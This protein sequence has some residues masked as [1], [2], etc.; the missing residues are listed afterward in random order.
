M[1]QSRTAFS[2]NVALRLVVSG[3]VLTLAQVGPDFVILKETTTVNSDKAIVEVMIENRI[4]S[5]TAVALPN[6]ICPSEKRIAI[7]NT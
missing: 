7:S 4:A 3:Q 6:G 2:A 5:S 1:S